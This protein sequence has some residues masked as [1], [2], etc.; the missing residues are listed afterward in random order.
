MNAQLHDTTGTV[1]TKRNEGRRWLAAGVALV[2]IGLTFLAWQFLPLGVWPLLLLGM[3]FT[4]IGA[5][6]RMVG[7]IIPGG[8]L[9][10]VGLG[11][12]LSESWLATGDTAQGGLF[13]LGFALGWA[14]IDLLARLFTGKPQVWALVTA[15]VMALIGTPLLFGAAGEVA[16]ETVLQWASYAFPLALI[17]AGILAVARGARR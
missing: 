15:G 5:A 4:A 6:T 7:L 12:L 8:V 17:V 14:S 2:G 9:N 3:L 13:F 1:G 11:A 10:G 16:L